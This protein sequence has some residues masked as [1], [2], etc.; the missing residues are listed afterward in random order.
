MTATE[1]ELLER[2]AE[3]LEDERPFSETAAALRSL[4]SLA[5]R[6]ALWATEA[7][8]GHPRPQSCYGCVLAAEARRAGLLPESGSGDA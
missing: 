4:L 7:H 5:G 8:I 6:L 3:G 1:L 2:F